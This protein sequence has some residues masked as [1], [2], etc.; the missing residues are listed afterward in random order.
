[1]VGSVGVFLGLGL[2]DGWLRMRE[3][4]W[5]FVFILLS[6]LYYHIRLYVKIRTVMWSIIVK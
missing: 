1:M 6:S 3:R 5:S 4:K 2:C